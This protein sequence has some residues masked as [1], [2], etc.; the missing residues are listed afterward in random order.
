MSRFTTWNL[1]NLCKAA[2][3][4]ITL[5]VFP[6]FAQSQDETRRQVEKPLEENTLQSDAAYFESHVLPLLKEKCFDCHSHEAGEANGNL[7]LDSA[8]AIAAGG[9]RGPAINMANLAKSPFVTAV[10]Y[11]DPDLQMPPDGKLS[12]AEMEIL[13]KWIVGGA[14]FP[15]HLG[16]KH[17]LDDEAKIDPTSHWAYQ[18]LGTHKTEA[19]PS[20][21]PTQPNQPLNTEF[22]RLLFRELDNKGLK[23][24]QIADRATLLRRMSYDITG[25]PPTFE[26]TQAFIHDS[27]PT[28]QAVENALER[29]LSSPRFGERWA[30]HWMDLA[31]YADNKGYVF[32]EDREYPE[33]YR[34][35]DW[36]IQAF[37]NDLPY[38]QFVIQQLAADKLAASHPDH[39][40]DE[41]L[42]ALGF[43]TLGRRFLNNQFDII[44]D[45]IDVVSRGLMGMTLACARCHDHKYDPLTQGD[46]YSMAGVFLNSK[47][48]GGEPFAHRLQDAEK[49]RDS[50]ILVRG[51]VGQIGPKVERQFVRFLGPD[52]PPY[53]DGSGRLELAQEI[54][55]SQNPLTA[56]VI[57]NRIWMKL[58]GSSL[59]ESPSDFG[60]RCP[61]P[62]QIDLLDSLAAYLIKHDWNLKSLV[63]R[64]MQSHAYQQSSDHNESAFATDPVN[65]L[66]WKMNRKRLDFE[67]MRDTLLVST[68]KLNASVGG[69]SERIDKAP[70]S[71]RRTLYAYIDRQNLPAVFRTFDLA[72]PDV[73]S[74]K[75]AETSVPQQG[76]FALNSE[77]ISKL[78]S[79]RARPLDLAAERSEKFDIRA[80]ISTLFRDI[81]GRNPSKEEILLV[82]N[83][84]SQQSDTSKPGGNWEYGY[85]QLAP[86]AGSLKGFV[87]LPACHKGRWQGGAKLPDPALGWCMLDAAGGHPGNDSD[88]A[89]IRRW[90]ALR[91]GTLRITGQLSHTSPEGNGVRA[92]LLVDNQRVNS[93]SVHKS[94]T[95]TQAKLVKVDAGSTIDFVVDSLGNES[96]DSFKWNVKISYSDGSNEQFDSARQFS[97]TKIQPIGPWAQVVQALLASNELMFVD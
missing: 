27:S 59:V 10:L 20:T 58:M 2:L 22:D 50:F 17:S 86:D 7:M 82:E 76:L 54:V 23:F 72:S 30:R 90:N 69:K 11:E 18:P 24:S 32:R 41:N 36:L 1:L 3:A 5:I 43:L 60:L 94:Q 63:R 52:K 45:R 35:R 75:R 53:K 48:P 13:K 74:P 21:T 88:F 85:G 46:Y 34:Y 14:V 84:L 71:Y 19:K 70:F 28:D 37:N 15:A 31:R 73:H 57:A 56:R 96:F 62:S 65:S 38:D 91:K 67:A 89:V 92:T 78:A 29:L 26:E 93:W 55:S 39:A 97:E 66:Y 42:P 49:M 16:A 61:Q 77:F 4:A 83:F 25:L 80:E 33:A 40:K 8:A 44:D 64:I 9:T 6:C 95:N 12:P 81:L 47:E 68:G 51:S 79:A 87:H